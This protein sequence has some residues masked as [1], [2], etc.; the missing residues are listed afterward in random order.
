MKNLLI[1]SFIL[2]CLTTQA[3]DLIYRDTLPFDPDTLNIEELCQ[4]YKTDKCADKHNYV[5]HYYE[6]FFPIRH[7]AERILEIGMLHGA[8]HHLWKDYF[9]NAEIYG[10][11][12]DTNVIINE[13]RIHSMIADQSDRVALKAFTDSFPGQFDVIIDDGGHSLEQQQVS[14]AYLFQFVKPGGYFII[15]DVHTSLPEYYPPQFY[16]VNADTSNT[17]LE[18]IHTYLEEHSMESLYMTEEEQGYLE[19]SIWYMQLNFTSD[20]L[21]SV[22]CI[23]RKK[24]E[25]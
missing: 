9:S 8:S 11:D 4:K 24:E 23:I 13:G 7:S 25:D 2:G 18:M 6:F 3:Q 12:I 16:G 5:T 22:C 19:N 17:T 21:H 20:E 10:I 15:E 14:F 1:A